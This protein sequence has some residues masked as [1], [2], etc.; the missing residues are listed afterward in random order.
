MNS[1]TAD[2]LAKL[3]VT[4]HR[5]SRIAAQATGSTTP[6]AVWHT[7]SVLTSDG[8]L[9]IGEL[10]RMARVTQPSMTKVVQQLDHGGLVHRVADAA[11]SRAWLVAITPA[12]TQALDEWRTELAAELEPA[13]ADLS[14]SDAATLE[15]AV[16][17]LGSRISTA[18]VGA[19]RNAA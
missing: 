3:L 4:A 13:F 7:L 11:D 5:L 8:P 14:A 9:R 10:A 17:I 18:R 6:S 19:G 2:L 12:G 15:R 16:D 1:P